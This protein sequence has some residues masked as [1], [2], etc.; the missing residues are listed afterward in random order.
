MTRPTTHLL[1]TT[2]VTIR[3][4]MIPIDAHLRGGEG[5]S[6]SGVI[7]QILSHSPLMSEVATHM[8]M[9]HLRLGHMPNHHRGEQILV[10]IL[11]HP[12]ITTVFDIRCISPHPRDRGLLE[13]HCHLAMT[14]LLTLLPLLQHPIGPIL[15]T[16]HLITGLHPVLPARMAVLLYQGARAVTM[17]RQ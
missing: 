12:L 6:L 2:P 7:L 5:P 3:Q 9:F 10:N 16:N 14:G 11:H 1:C 13:G 4:C 15:E 8:H 17:R